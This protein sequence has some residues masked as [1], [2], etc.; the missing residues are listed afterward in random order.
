[1]AKGFFNRD[2]ALFLDA[3]KV[4]GRRR[5]LDFDGLKTSYGIGVRFHTPLSTPLRIE[6][7]RTGDGLA[8]VFGFGPSF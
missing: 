1:M 5:D 4:V 6:L 7:A 2:M 8:L 3:G